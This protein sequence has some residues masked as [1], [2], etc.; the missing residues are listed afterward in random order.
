[1]TEP[2]TDRATGAADELATR[3]PAQGSS[4][5]CGARMRLQYVKPHLKAREVEVW[6]FACPRCEYRLHVIR[7][8]GVDM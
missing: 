6:V 1:M 7:P 3:F 2:Q 4:C 5:A 8:L